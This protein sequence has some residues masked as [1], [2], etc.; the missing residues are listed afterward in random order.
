MGYLYQEKTHLQSTKSRLI[1][2]QDTF[3]IV[4]LPTTKFFEVLNSSLPFMVRAMV[5]GDL[6]G[7][8]P[9]RYTIGWKYLYLVYN[10]DAKP[11]LFYPLNSQQAYK[12]ETVC[13]LL[14]FWLARYENCSTSIRI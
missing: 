6:T 2:S 13:K 14:S 11:I 3:L 9:Y 4:K 7:A 10:F 12:I 5:Y 8:F 1:D